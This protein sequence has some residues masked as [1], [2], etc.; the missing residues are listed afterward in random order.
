MVMIIIIIIMQYLIKLLYVF[1]IASI[2][3]FVSNDVTVYENDGMVEVC[4]Q[5]YDQTSHDVYI[6]LTA[7]ERNNPPNLPG[8]A[9]G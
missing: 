2:L 8:D 3:R 1:S 7:K 9:L 4:I 5:K 6:S